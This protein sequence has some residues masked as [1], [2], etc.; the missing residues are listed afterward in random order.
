MFINYCTTDPAAVA[1]HQGP[2]APVTVD[3]IAAVAAVARSST[4][5]ARENMRNSEIEDSKQIEVSMAAQQGGERVSE[6]EHERVGTEGRKREDI[7]RQR[8]EHRSGA[9]RNSRGTGSRSCTY[10]S[11]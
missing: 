6:R 10:S 4:C 5:A 2:T 3:A 1:R 7:R 8:G 11:K 9:G